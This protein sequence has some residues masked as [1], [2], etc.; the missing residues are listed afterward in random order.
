MEI[1]VKIP[2]TEV[3]SKDYFQWSI[4]EQENEETLN[5]IDSNYFNQYIFTN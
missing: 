2:D 3:D 4:S 5:W 1:E